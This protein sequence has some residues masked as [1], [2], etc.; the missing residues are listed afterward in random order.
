MTDPRSSKEKLKTAIADEKFAQRQTRK[1]Y[2]QLTTKMK[3]Y[4]M[5]RGP[6]PTADE[7]SLWSEAVEQRIKIREL[8]INIDAE[9]RNAS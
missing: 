2:D 7:F 4:Q 6:A 8:A 3:A 9:F 1:I 5:G